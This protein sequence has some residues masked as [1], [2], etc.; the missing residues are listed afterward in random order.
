MDGTLRIE[1]AGPIPGLEYDQLLVGE[2][3]ILNGEIEV[4]L[5][6]GFVPDV[7]DVFDI[8]IAD[9]GFEFGDLFSIVFPALPNGHRLAYSLVSL[10]GGRTAFRIFDPPAEDVPEPATLTLVGIG[11]MTLA[12]IRRKSRV[13]TISC[14]MPERRS[15]FGLSR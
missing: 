10:D 5:L 8:I 6:D 15:P 14:P 11:L 9:G 4:V 7:S 1:I 3:A 12:L 2:K 13:A